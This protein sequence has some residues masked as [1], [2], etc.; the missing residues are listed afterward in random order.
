MGHAS[1]YGLEQS[2]LIMNVFSVMAIATS[3]YYLKII[4]SEFK[5][6]NQKIDDILSFLYG[7][8]KS[9]LISE[10]CF[11]QHACKN[12]SAIMEHDGQRIATITNLQ[13]AQKT[14]VKDIEFYISDMNKKVEP[15]FKNYSEFKG[16]AEKI[17]KLKDSLEMAIQLY[18]MSNIMEV[19]YSRNYDE[20]YIS[21]IKDTTIYYINKCEKQMIY[22]FGR[23][24]AAYN[25]FQGNKINKINNDYIGKN[26]N[27]V[28]DSL[29]VGEDSKLNSIVKLT[30]DDMSK[31]YVFRIDKSGNVYKVA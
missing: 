7:E 26:I 20:N 10:I 30:F 29:N 27:K 13:A 4:S 25:N 8:K 14:A 9:E 28:I 12:F 16:V 15:K 1:L 11:V 18:A 2:A 6:L 5:M 24:A 31:D 23:L 19:S 17:F 21:D 22:V 3:Q